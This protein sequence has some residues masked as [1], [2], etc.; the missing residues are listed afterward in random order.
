VLADPDR[1]MQVFTNLLS[2]AAK[3][4]LDSGQVHISMDSRGSKIRFSVRDYGTGIPY[5][6]R[7]RIFQKFSQADSSDKRRC[8]GTGLGLSIAK[9]IVESMHGSLNFESE[10]GVGTTF[11]F[12]LPKADHANM[13]EKKI[14]TQGAA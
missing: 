3:F 9:K 1:L 5:E 12:D 11:Y 6:F 8:E 13:D 2:N 10:I 4:S 7:S 14:L